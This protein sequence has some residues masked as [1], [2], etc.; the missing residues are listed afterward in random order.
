MLKLVY[1]AARTHLQRLQC[2]HQYATHI[3]SHRGQKYHTYIQRTCTCQHELKQMRQRL[4][5]DR[6]LVSSIEV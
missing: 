1:I 2:A 3:S 6:G 4:L 5:I